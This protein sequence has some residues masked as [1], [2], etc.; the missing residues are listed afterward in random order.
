VDANAY[1]N[2]SVASDL[3]GGDFFFERTTLLPAPIVNPEGL[4]RPDYC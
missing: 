3:V 2:L 1:V 4:F